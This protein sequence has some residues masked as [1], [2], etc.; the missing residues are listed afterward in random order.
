MEYTGTYNCIIVDDDEIDRL[1]TLSYARKYPYLEICGVCSSAAEA[2]KIMDEENIDLMLS[3]IDMPELTGFDFRRRMINV[4]VCIFITSYADCAVESFELAALDFLVKPVKSGRFEAAMKR[5][6]EYLDARHKAKLYE[7]SLGADTIFLKDGHT[8][9]KVNLHDILYLEALK[10]YTLVV[11]APKRYCVLSPIGSLLKESH[12]K[13]FIRVHR[14]FA[15]QKHLIEKINTNQV[16]INNVAIPIGRSYK[17][18]L[19]V[20]NNKV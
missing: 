13:T 17:E 11:T 1:T 18:N 12:F 8:F 16:I 3:D 14:S 19:G 10:D 7:Y 5:A 9:I 6:K 2:L 4:P 20:I 15:V